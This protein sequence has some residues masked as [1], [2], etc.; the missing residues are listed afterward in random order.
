MIPMLSNKKN[1]SI[2]LAIAVFLFL[3]FTFIYFPLL[4]EIRERGFLWKSLGEQLKM[5][6][7]LRDFQK[8]G[9]HKRFVSQKELVLV[10][11]KITEAAKSRLLEFRSISQQ[12]IKAIDGYRVLPVEMEIDADYKHLG[13]FLGDLENL[14][15]ALVTVKNIQINSDEKLLPRIS[16]SLTINIY[17]THD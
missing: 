14:Q 15:D 17:I 3:L 7:N 2:I 10:L 13:L 8:A 9:I 1:L 16:S 11:D 12:E 4:G 5:A 6:E